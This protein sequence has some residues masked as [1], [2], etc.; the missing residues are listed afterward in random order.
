LSS[1]PRRLLD[2]SVTSPA[3][4]LAGALHAGIKS[5]P[6]K[7]DLVLLVSEQPCAVAATFTNNR[8]A[9]APVQL[10][11]E[12]VTSGRARAVVIN[13]GNANACTGD[14]GLENARQM[15]RWAAEKVGAS[16][17]EVLVASTG[18]IGVQLPIGRIRDGLARLEVSRDG[19]LLAARGIMTTDTRPKHLAVELLIDGTMVRLGG[20]SKGAGM[21]HPN[22]ATMLCFVTTDVAGE[23]DYFQAALER[24]V[25]NSFNMITVDG[26]TSTND[27][28]LLLANG[29]SDVRLDGRGP[30]AELFQR[31]LDEVAQYLA[32]AIVADAEGAERTMR[33]E[34]RGASSEG[35]ARRAARAVASSSLTKAALHG[36][37][38]NWGRI[39]CAVG[40]SGA[41]LDPDLVEL[42]IGDVRLVRD[43]APVDFDALAASDAMKRD[44]VH[45]VV[46]L[47]QGSGSAISWGCELTEAYV[48]ENSAYTT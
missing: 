33:I 15:A 20:M 34:V 18:V 24:A 22:M 41:D 38:P 25:A 23:S 35:D 28:C 5:D 31:A 42:W 45:I 4:F 13:S 21:I 39:L 9:A 48:V 2:G 47:H 17:E 37:D 43:G 44:E 7:P 26:D 3:G 12:R 6:D 30:G 19:G 14:Q 27:T 16:T 32:R 1:E 11:R 29:A 46:D 10:D 40:Y 36:A 8:F